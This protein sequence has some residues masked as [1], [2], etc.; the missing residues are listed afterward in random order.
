MVLS[1]CFEVFIREKILDG[2]QSSTITFYEYSVKKLISFVE[3]QDGD[4]SVNELHLYIQ[5]FFISLKKIPVYLLT[6]T[7][8]WSGVL[9]Y[10]HGF[11]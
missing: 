5:P 8:R 9:R 6:H 11:S 1:E 3:D 10:S 2:C 7:T 4:I